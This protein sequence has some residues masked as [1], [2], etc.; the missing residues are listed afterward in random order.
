MKNTIK[1]NIA[2]WLNQLNE[3]NRKVNFVYIGL[4]V[5]IIWFS[6]INFIIVFVLK[7]L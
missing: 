1:S 2:I 6:V 7:Y 5:L 4:V 3:L